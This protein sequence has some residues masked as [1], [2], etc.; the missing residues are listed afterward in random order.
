MKTANDLLRA[1]DEQMRGALPTLPPGAR[2][3]Q[4]GPLWRVVGCAQGFIN[5]PRDVGVRGAELDRLIAR[6]RDHFAERG[7]AVEWKTY[8][9]D[10]PADLTDRLRTAGFVPE[11][12]ET[13]VIGLAREL[14]A[15]PAP[16]P[17]GVLLRQVDSPADIRRIMD[18]QNA[19]WGRD[20]N[21]LGDEL[22]ARIAADPDE[23]VVLVAEAGDRIVSAAWIA[24]VAGT[25]FAG[26]WGGTTVPE[27]RG[28]GIYRALVAERARHAVA[29]GVSYLQVDASQD[30]LPILRRL[31]F[32]VATVTTPYV[33]SP[34]A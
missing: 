4:D 18:M 2:N 33:W 24:F 27:W 15:E 25:E 17:D 9:H 31:G 3:E 20:W 1:F 34:D 29:R 14:A 19:V 10:E 12:P 7:E 22:I 8:A 32:H 21:W 30:S 6:Q 13:L 26:L 5:A 16:P 11:E 28:R 23:L